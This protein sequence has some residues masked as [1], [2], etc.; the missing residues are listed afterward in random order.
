MTTP[1]VFSFADI[2]QD[3][4]GSATPDVAG[5]ARLYNESGSNTNGAMTQSAVTT[6]FNDAYIAGADLLDGQHGSYYQ[7]AANLNAGTL[8]AARLPAHTGDVTSSAGSAN[9]TL[10]ASSVLSKLL[11]VD[12]TGSG[13]DADLLDG[14]HASVFAKLGTSVSFSNISLGTNISTFINNKNCLT[15]P[16]ITW[17][18]S[19]N[20]SSG[21]IGYS[22]NIFADG[23]ISNSIISNGTL[24]YFPAFNGFN[25]YGHMFYIPNVFN[26]TNKIFYIRSLIDSDW[27][28]DHWYSF[29]TNVR[30]AV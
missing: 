18:K 25:V 14:Q 27:L 19:L 4:V 20:N 26:P 15:V 22:K 12:G 29:A 3:I 6:A 10:T 11:T 16:I 5:I 8:P 23:A 13:L 7:N 21:S 17:V 1:P 24:I 2:G 28:D 30:V 9:L